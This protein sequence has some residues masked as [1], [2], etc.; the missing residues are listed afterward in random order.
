M[1]R[2]KAQIIG[3]LTIA[4]TISSVV[5]LAKFYTSPVKKMPINNQQQQSSPDKLLNEIKMLG[6]EMVYQPCPFSERD[7]NNTIENMKDI[8]ARGKEKLKKINPQA[9]EWQEANKQVQS[10]QKSYQQKYEKYNV[11]YRNAIRMGAKP[12]CGGDFMLAPAPEE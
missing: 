11:K 10:L 3:A 1:R 4:A 8:V 7:I 9:Q 12:T 6:I 5:L 2:K